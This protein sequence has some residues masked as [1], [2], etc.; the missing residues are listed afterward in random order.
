MTTHAASIA[1]QIAQ[2]P[3]LPMD[4]LW[5]MWDEFFDRRPGHHHR[6]YLESRIAYRM[7]ERAFGGLPETIRR[8]LEKIGETGVVPNQ[9]RRA[10]TQ[11]AH[12]TMLIRE[13]NGSSH[14]VTVLIDGKFDYDGRSYKSLSAI[15]RLI[16]GV[17]WSGPAFF[18]LKTS[19]RLTAS[20]SGVE[21]AAR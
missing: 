20:G 6:T 4:N 12:G 5:A 2:L 14:R 16:T 7:Q 3:T 9:R 15:A 18:G 8:K 21:V 13:Y 17:Q 19:R 1:S 10:E 11:L